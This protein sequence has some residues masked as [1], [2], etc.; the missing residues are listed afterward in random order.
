MHPEPG[1]SSARFETLGRRGEGQMGTLYLA[2]QSKPKRRFAL[3]VV[4]P[5]RRSRLNR[6]HSPARQPLTHSRPHHESRHQSHLVPRVV[7]WDEARGWSL[8]HDAGPT[9]PTCLDDQPTEVW[10]AVARAFGTVQRNTG[11]GPDDW[12]T[13]GCRDQRGG[14]LLKALQAMIGH[15]SPELDTTDRDGLARLLPRIEEAC[16]DLAHDGVPATLVHQD[17]VPENLVWKDKQVVFLD[18]SDTVVGHPF[19]GL[20]RL[21]GFCWNDATRKAAVIADYLA[22]FQDAA[23]PERLQRSFDRVLWLRVLYEGLRWYHE[24]QALAPTSEHAKWLRADQLQG[25]TMFA[26]RQP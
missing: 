14:R 18:W 3:K 13:V 19:F 25:L 23:S 15:A 22:V 16:K 5:G 2:L 20:D 26:Q 7:A 12:V 10:R 17:L 9:G 21:I 1:E 6:R 11:R 8:T 4:S 24:V